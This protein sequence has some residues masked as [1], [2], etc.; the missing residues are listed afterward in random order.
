MAKASREALPASSLVDSAAPKRR[1]EA[2]LSRIQSPRPSDSSGLPRMRESRARSR[3]ASRRAPASSIA[4][5]PAP[6]RSRDAHSCFVCISRVPP[7]RHQA[8]ADSSR[9]PAEAYH[10]GFRQSPALRSRLLRIPGPRTF[11]V[12]FDRLSS[13]RATSALLLGACLFAWLVPCLSTA[14]VVIAREVN[15][16]SNPH[17][18]CP[19]PEDGSRCDC[20]CCSA[21]EHHNS[22]LPTMCGECLPED[23]TPAVVTSPEAVPARPTV[24]PPPAWQ[25]ELVLSPKSETIRQPGRKPDPIPRTRV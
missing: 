23:P 20:P 13:M 17:C 16:C 8:L 24:L 14:D 2:L 12:V 5:H 3:S 11:S 4:I 9:R 22:G 1:P 7:G 18:V 10:P 19:I 15:A 25:V 6:I 21:D